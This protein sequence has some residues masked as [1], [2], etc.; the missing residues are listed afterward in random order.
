MASRRK[1]LKK[2]QIGLLKQAE[3]HRIKAETLRGRKDTTQDYWIKEAER[4]E[5]RARQRKE[6]L[7]KLTKKRMKIIKNEI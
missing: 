2:Q 7:E 3:K 1:R 4:F 6:L 5:E